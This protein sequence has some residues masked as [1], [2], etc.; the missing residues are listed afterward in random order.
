MKKNPVNMYDIRTGNVIETQKEKP[1]DRWN[2]DIYS[3]EQ[4]MHLIRTQE[5][6]KHGFIVY[7]EYSAG[8]LP[9]IT[10]FDDYID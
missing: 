1:D 3:L 6:P 8:D 10:I 2:I 9:T 5:G 4:L 7:T